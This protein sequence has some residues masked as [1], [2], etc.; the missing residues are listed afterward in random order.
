MVAMTMRSVLIL[1]AAL[2]AGC[3]SGV[4]VPGVVADDDPSNPAAP[5]GQMPAISQ[6]LATRD[7]PVTMPAAE[8]KKPADGG[9]QHHAH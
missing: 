7:G 2:L 3:G 6:T 8:V 5:A 4:V 9:H 1:S